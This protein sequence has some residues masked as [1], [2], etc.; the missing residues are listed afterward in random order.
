MGKFKVQ[1]IS[2]LL[3][4]ILKVIE[5]RKNLVKLIN[6]LSNYL[7]CAD[8]SLFYLDNTQH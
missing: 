1:V 4:C 3:C 7:Q 8:N 6:I 5:K 2:L